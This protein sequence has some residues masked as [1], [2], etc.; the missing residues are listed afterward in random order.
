MK[1][2]FVAALLISAA[3]PAVWSLKCYV[4][5]STESWD[6]CKDKEV[7]ATCVAPAADKCVKVYYK[8]G[9]LQTFTKSCGADS[10]CDQKTNPHCKDAI[11][12]FECD[13]N[14]CSGDDCNA[15]SATR[16][17]GILLL[18]CA[19]VSLMIFFKA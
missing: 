12:S 17:S 10:Y 7:S 16:I 19:L 9:S 14:C 5:T 15:G 11:G 8:F 6:K 2:W 18:S 3:L 13:I 4:C 1:L